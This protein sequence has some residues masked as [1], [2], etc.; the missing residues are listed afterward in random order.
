MNEKKSHLHR[1]K[2]DVEAFPKKKRYDFCRQ[3]FIDTTG[4]RIKVKLG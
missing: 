3:N 2:L 1:L 4:S